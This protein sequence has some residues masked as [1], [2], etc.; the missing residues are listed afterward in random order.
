MQDDS[1]TRTALL[2]AALAHVAFDGWGVKALNAGAADMG[3]DPGTAARL[4]PGG[5]RE[6]ARA[7]SDWADE[8][9]VA[10]LEEQDLA[11]LKVR[12]RIAAA[13]RA[14]MEALGPHREAVRVLLSYLALPGNGAFASGC[15]Y[16]TVDAA[17]RGIGD[18][19]TDFNFYTK[20][21]LL[22]GVVASTTLYWLNDTSP[23]R[24]ESWRF[25][26][27]RISNVL[28][29]QKIRGRLEKACV[30]L[31]DPFRLRRGARRS[32]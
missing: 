6:L 32:A 24:V 3:C 20:R 25:L 16:R 9:M 5:A 2:L 31:P 21:G 11:A 17:W 22:A 23:D 7:F 14:R 12:D 27:R 15:L 28:A 8:R 29:I 26:D 4:F 30:A 10:A 19:S 18:S 13:V 1:K